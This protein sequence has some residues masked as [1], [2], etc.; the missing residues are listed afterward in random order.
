MVETAHVS[1]SCYAI[2]YIDGKLTSLHEFNLCDSDDIDFTRQCLSLNSF[3]SRE[4]QRVIASLQDR[5]R[6]KAATYCRLCARSEF[7]EIESQI[8]SARVFH[9]SS[10]WDFYKT[11][12][13]DVMTRRYS[14]D[15]T[16]NPPQV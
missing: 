1:P 5:D 14:G 2:L 6:N 11:I 15:V 9:H 13:Y 8:E 4:R 16:T 7:Y 12:G 3:G 10:I